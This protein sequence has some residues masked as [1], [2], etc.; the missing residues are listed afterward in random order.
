MPRARNRVFL[1]AFLIAA[2]LPMPARALSPFVRDT[3]RLVPVVC[4]IE[5]TIFSTF[6]HLAGTAFQS[7]PAAVAAPTSPD[8]YAGQA[9]IP[10]GAPSADPA[11][12]QPPALLT[13]AR[14]NTS[15]PPPSARTLPTQQTDDE[16]LLALHTQLLGT[17]ASN[18]ANLTASVSALSA[19]RSFFAEG[20]GRAPQPAPIFVPQYVA[21]N[22]FGGGYSGNPATTRIDSLSNVTI[23]NP[24]S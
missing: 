11:A 8:G 5:S 21:G 3:C 4:S 13:A 1:T 20:Y 15:L 19:Q 2:V 18:M 6:Q 17:L 23:G 24:T 14:T 16:S 7:Q 22:G 10:L 9:P 12:Y